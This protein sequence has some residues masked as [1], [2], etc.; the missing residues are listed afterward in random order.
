[1]WVCWPFKMSMRSLRNKS[2]CFC[3]C[4]CFQTSGCLYIMQWKW[5]PSPDP[6]TKPYPHWANQV[7]LSK[8]PLSL[9]PRPLIIT[10]LQRPVLV[11]NSWTVWQKTFCDLCFQRGFSISSCLHC[12]DI[13]MF[14]MH[15]TSQTNWHAL[16]FEQYAVASLCVVT[17]YWNKGCVLSGI[18]L[19][20]AI[21]F[22]KSQQLTLFNAECY[23]RLIS[24][25]KFGQTFGRTSNFIRPN[26]HTLWASFM[27][28]KN[29]FWSSCHIYPTVCFQVICMQKYD[30]AVYVHKSR[31]NF[32]VIIHKNIL[33]QFVALNLMQ[34]TFRTIYILFVLVFH[35]FLKHDVHINHLWIVN[36]A[37]IPSL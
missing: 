14:P 29:D 20:S 28:H 16:H 35:T 12:V 4:G 7:T 9:W 24:W 34:M 30:V 13:G 6:T 1:M 22:Y 31:L 23:C 36:E 33:S 32:C 11:Q 10:V 8:T 2:G 5:S 18:K 19:C 17:S 3:I 15:C 26:T 27:K 21:K 37:F 25:A